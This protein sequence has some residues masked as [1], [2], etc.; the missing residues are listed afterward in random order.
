MTI[1]QIKKIGELIQRIEADMI[2]AYIVSKDEKQFTVKATQI[3]D[4][5]HDKI[6]DIISDLGIDK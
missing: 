1:K 2:H 3:V 6:R 4:K 5:A